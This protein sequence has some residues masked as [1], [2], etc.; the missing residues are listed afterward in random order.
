MD[1]ECKSSS[2]SVAIV[3]GF[4]S[5]LKSY[6]VISYC[7]LVGCLYVMWVYVCVLCCACV[8]VC[9]V[10]VC[11]CMYVYVY[12]PWCIWVY[13]LI[14][15]GSTFLGIILYFPLLYKSLFLLFLIYSIVQ[16]RYQQLSQNFF[17][18]ISEL[19]E[20]MQ[21][22]DWRVEVLN[23]KIDLVDQ[24]G[25]YNCHLFSLLL[26]FPPSSLAHFHLPLCVYFFLLLWLCS[27][28]YLSACG[29]W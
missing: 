1:F 8:C 20:R 26:Y 5:D 3:D 7:W 27:A 14:S 9:V 28:F 11:L 22:L 24:L 29:W 2:S 21:L 10:F 15:T 25:G 17:G 16:K 23:V 12:V 13:S 6:Q 18:L 4:A 19:V